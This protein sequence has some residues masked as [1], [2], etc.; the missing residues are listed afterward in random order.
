MSWWWISGRRWC[1]PCHLQAEILKKLLVDYGS[2]TVDV[3]GVNLGEDAATVSAALRAEPLPYPVL[4]DPADE[5]T[6]T[7][8]DR[9]FAEPA[10]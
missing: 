1:G 10:W 2:G 6:G 5:L 7:A 9:R 3:F 4:L 8:R